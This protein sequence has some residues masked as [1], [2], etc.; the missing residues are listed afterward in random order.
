MVV[1][2]NSSYIYS[3]SIVG[4]VVVLLFNA[5]LTMVMVYVTA[6]LWWSMWQLTSIPGHSFWSALRKLRALHLHDNPLGKFET[7]QSLS[8]APVL[9][10]VTLFDTPLYLKKN[11]RHHVVNSIWTLKAL[12]HHVVSDEEIIEDAMFGGHFSALSPSLKLDL[13]PASPMV[14]TGKTGKQVSKHKKKLCR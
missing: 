9:A 5:I 3:F 7:L 1:Y 8:A 11:Y 2:S 12:D 14:S 6:Y 4:G 13:C 10:I